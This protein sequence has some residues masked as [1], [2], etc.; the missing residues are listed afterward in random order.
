MAEREAWIFVDFGGDPLQK[1]GK[2]IHERGS[3]VGG[4]TLL[5]K[6]WAF[7]CGIG[8][9]VSDPLHVCSRICV[10]IQ[11]VCA[12]FA[13]TAVRVL[14]EVAADAHAALASWCHA[15]IETGVGCVNSPLPFCLRCT[16]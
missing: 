6:I 9:Q 12:G 3:F 1:G 4:C 5:T 8:R 10:Q 11:D 16:R 15:L 2:N 13:H 7:V 14:A